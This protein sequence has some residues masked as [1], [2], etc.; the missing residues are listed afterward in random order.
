MKALTDG[1]F[2][3][4]AA[5]LAPFAGVFGAE[6]LLE[7]R[8]EIVLRED[9]LHLKIGARA[10]IEL[11]PIPGDLFSSRGFKLRFQLSGDGAPSSFVLD[12]GRVRGIVF[13]RVGR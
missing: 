13:E 8:Y 9:A 7:V 5:D 6:D 2:E 3:P 4:S 1:S 11:T 10:E 12:A